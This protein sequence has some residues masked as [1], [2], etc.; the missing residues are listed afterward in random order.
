MLTL[1]ITML[2][3]VLLAAVV[4]MYVAFPHRGEDL[5]GA[6]W[7]GKLVRRSVTAL[8]VERNETKRPEG[9]QL[10]G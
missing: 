9:E 2:I 5:P 4:V 6:R 3:I 8:P 10:F 1:V 7:L